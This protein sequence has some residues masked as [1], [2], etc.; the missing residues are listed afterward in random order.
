[1]R[2]LPSGRVMYAVA[3]IAAAIAT[4][5]RARK[6]EGP[7]AWPLLAVPTFSRRRYAFVPVFREGRVGAA[8]RA[9]PS[10]QSSSSKSSKPPSCF[11]PRGGSFPC[12]QGD[13]FHGAGHKKRPRL[14]GVR[15]VPRSGDHRTAQSP[16]LDRKAFQAVRGP[17]TAGPMAGRSRVLPTRPG[18]SEVAVVLRGP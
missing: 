10:G 18:L 3:S 6:R 9:G 2:A 5:T 15:C 4:P 11:A 13:T 14:S 12:R 16:H 1:M 8:C 7:K 17:A